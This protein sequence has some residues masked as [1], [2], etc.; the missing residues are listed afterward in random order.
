MSK[1]LFL[2]SRIAISLVVIVLLL[3]L[4]FDKLI[5][6][7]I[8]VTS[9]MIIGY[10][11]FYKAG[12][13]LR[14]LDISENVLMSIGAIAAV[15][16]GEYPEGVAIMVFFQIGE[17]FEGYATNKSRNILESL[18]SIR[19][20]VA[21]V[22]KDD[23][24][25]I[26][27]LPQGVQQNS[28]ITIMKGERI[29]L[30][31]ELLSDNADIDAS[32]ISGESLPISLNKGGKVL[33]GAVNIG[34][35]FNVRVSSSYYDSTIAR[36]LDLIENASSAKSKQEAFITSFARI[37]TPI[38][39]SCA[40]VFAFLPLFIPG[41]QWDEYIHR[42]LVF[43]VVS[44]PCALLLAVPMVFFGGLGALAK[45][46]ILVKGGNLLNK[47][48]KLNYLALDKTGTLTTGRFNI[49]E[50]EYLCS[51]KDM[52]RNI[53]LSLE[54]FSN[55]PLAKSIVEE[56][57]KDSYKSKIIFEE[58]NEI[59]GVGIRGEYLGEKYYAV[60]PN[61]VRDVLG[62]ELNSS[63]NHGVV[64]IASNTKILGIIKLEDTIKAESSFFV[65]KAKEHGFKLEILSGDN[66]AIVE[67]VSSF[68]K[69]EKSKG[70]CSPKDKL[71]VIESRCN[72]KDLVTGFVGDG[73]NDAPVLSRVDIGFAM[74][75]I[76][77][78]IAMDA[79][80]VIIMNDNLNRIIE[81][82]IIAKRILNLVKWLITFILG[83]K[84]A[85]LIIGALGYASMWLAIF[86]DV[87]VT[88]ISVLLAMITFSRK[89]R[90][91]NLDDAT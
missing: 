11:I 75:K 71:N 40:V 84:I 19:P 53:A 51:D 6:I 33:S 4:D 10:E 48:S 65:K 25:V 27:M 14:H 38:V 78:A 80:D 54:K 68:L 58:V 23:G 87:G 47:L 88:V 37:Y 82:K 20:K 60:S 79:G 21:H 46:D 39:I 41:A 49:A 81:A 86:G 63:Y 61:Y 26:N 56:L 17:I 29:P 66:N 43:L 59:S 44:C 5:S 62:F 18:A 30:D 73:I 90:M 77:Q 72:S 76:G 3:T 45:R 91:V 50:F 70:E 12:I 89:F 55:H 35:V 83:M 64:V 85:I 9:L 31:G 22:L 28:I 74:G 8:S 13:N 67:K 34:G 7:C 69:I 15:A 57:Q 2:Y 24:T 52:V 36:L 1:N 32:A 42:S 16:I